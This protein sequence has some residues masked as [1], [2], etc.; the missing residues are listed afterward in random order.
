MPTGVEEVVG[1]A[2]GAISLLAAFK[3]AVDGYLLVESFFDKDNGLRDL[4]LDYRIECQK[5]EVWGDRFKVKADREEDCLLYKESDAVKKLMAEIFGRIQYLN[6]QAKSFVEF[7][8]ATDYA[9]DFTTL[10]TTFNKHLQLGGAEVKAMSD[11]QMAKQQKKRVKWAIKNKD[12]FQEIVEKLRKANTDLDALLSEESRQ[13][14]SKALPAYFLAPINNLDHLQQVQQIGTTQNSLLRQQA[15][16]KLLQTT[17]NGD[18]TGTTIAFDALQPLPTTSNTSGSRQI[19]IY[20]NVTRSWIEWLDIERTHTPVEEAHIRQRI[21]T[22]STM[23]ERTPT[24][25]HVARCIGHVEDPS[26]AF[27]IG[28]V[29]QLPSRSA[30]TSL[31][32][33]I[34]QYKA[35]KEPPLGDKFKLAHVLATT[36]MQ[37]HA[38]DWLHKAIRGDNVLFFA[39]GIVQPY[40]AG[41]EYARDVRMQSIGYRP[42]G[43]NTKD[44]YYHPDVVNG[45]TKILD[46]Y[47]LGVVLLEIAFWRPLGPKIPKQ[48][49]TSLE[50]I[51]AV[52]IDAAGDRLDAVVGTIYA[53]VVRAC[54]TCSLANLSSD[55]DFACAMNTEIVMQLERCKA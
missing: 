33:M 37:L 8:E 40:L 43:K 9:V 12:K 28:L 48:S 26:H 15:Q 10:G 27:R 22:L 18:P 17:P 35:R 34:E 13:A 53:D 38:S 55:G 31:L 51:R 29:Y 42:T 45:Y 30:P 23:L 1:L 6:T 32:S 20:S 21:K 16:L 49:A 25:F 14:A 3:G 2:I 47:S 36:L 50:A 44:Y 39:A 19:Y 7:H 11:A 41:F 4:A 5:L 52:C 24:S 46:L 54:L